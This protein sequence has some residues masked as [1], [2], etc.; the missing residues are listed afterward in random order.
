MCHVPR[1]ETTSLPFRFFR[2]EC[3]CLPQPVDYVE[4]RIGDGN[5]YSLTVDRARRNPAHWRA[6]ADAYA[7]WARP[8]LRLT[9]QRKIRVRVR[10]GTIALEP[11]Y[12]IAGRR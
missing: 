1:I 9:D 11:D 6:I 2:D 3:E 8:V 7:A 12:D 4:F 5:T 10:A